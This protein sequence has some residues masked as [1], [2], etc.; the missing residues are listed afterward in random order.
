M[1]K[2]PRQSIL[3][4]YYGIFIRTIRFHHLGTPILEQTAAG[5]SQRILGEILQDTPVRPLAVPVPRCTH[6]NHILPQPIPSAHI[7]P[8]KNLTPK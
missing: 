8:L 1:R 2:P 4:V 6:I 3:S 5:D 7:N